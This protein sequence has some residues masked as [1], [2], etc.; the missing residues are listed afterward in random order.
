[1]NKIPSAYFR[2]Q[3]KYYNFDSF[4]KELGLED[5][6]QIEKIIDRLRYRKLIKPTTQE[7]FNNAS[8]DE[9]F[10]DEI[11]IGKIAPGSNNGF[12]FDFVGIALVLLVL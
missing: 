7:Q 12:T 4:K 1:M 6:T 2:E 3:K 11:N 9:D 5:D 10:E 8:L